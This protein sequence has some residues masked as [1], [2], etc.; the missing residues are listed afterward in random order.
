MEYRARLEAA[1][2]RAETVAEQADDEFFKQF[3]RRHPMVEEYRTE[4]AEN[5]LIA[6]GTVAGTAR[7]VVDA[8]RAAGERVGLVKIHLFRPF[9]FN[10]IRRALS[11][12]RKV[13]I[14][15][16][17][18]SFGHGGI[19]ASEV[20]SALAGRTTPVPFFS[21][22]AGLGGRDV[23]PDTIDGVLDYMSTRAEPEDETL[24]VGLKE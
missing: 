22:I 10:A 2:R 24:W 7:G 5:L 15:D 11:R 8:R 19:M 21:F 17:S 12:A 20:R 4:D 14:I 16:R 9:P 6:S 13:A 18:I 23:T 3:G 1:V